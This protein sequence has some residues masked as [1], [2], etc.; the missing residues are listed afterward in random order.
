L[1]IE[2]TSVGDGR[3]AVPGNRWDLTLDPGDPLA[4][5]DTE[6]SVVVPFYDN[7][8]DLDLL[9]TALSL[10]THPSTRLQVVI[11]DDGSPRPPQV[12][13]QARGL[14][15]SVVGQQN[16]GFRAGTA[17]NLGVSRSEGEV[18]LFLDGDTVPGPDYVR[19]LSRLPAAIPD[20]VVSGRRRYADLSRWTPADLLTWFAG[21]DAG[22][23]GWEEPSWMTG[24]Y[25]RTGNLLRVH[26]RSYKYLIGAVLGCT[27]EMFDAVRGF[28]E[29]IVGYGGEDYDFTYRAYNSGAV[30]AYV[31]G[32]VAWH[33]GREWAGRTDPDLQSA[34]KNREM[35][36]LAARIPEPSMRGHGQI[37]PVVD[38]LVDVHGSGWTLGAGVLCIRSLLAT[39]DCAVTVVGEDE[40]CVDL[41]AAF[42]SDPRVRDALSLSEDQISSD[43]RARLHVVVR[44]AVRVTPS[45]ADRVGELLEADGGSLDVTAGGRSVVTVGSHRRRTRLARYPLL[46]AEVTDHWFSQCAM[47]HRESG[48]DLIAAEPRLAAVFGGY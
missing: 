25:E 15:I 16:A 31:P 48:V 35:M 17:R 44:E 1:T 34:Q 24:E 27:R 42:R 18:L 21:H 7:Q 11:A 5:R 13:D 32:A 30:L 43:A 23:T 29:S 9:L 40:S 6:T 47:D 28:D 33:D 22:P 37:Y 38:V 36:M 46:P 2:A 41:R 45:F 19:R 10:Q 39:L 14:N 8:H 26:P 4:Y 12:P 3:F 20:A